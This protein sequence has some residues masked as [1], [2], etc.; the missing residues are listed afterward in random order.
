[1]GEGELDSG[2][3]FTEPEIE[4]V[5]GTGPDPHQ[6]LVRGDPRLGDVL[7]L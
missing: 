1:V 4:V 5:Q 3:P 2:K 7:Y 6:D